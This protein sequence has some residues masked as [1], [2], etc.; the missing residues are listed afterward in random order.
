MEPLQLTIDPKA[1]AVVL[2]RLKDMPDKVPVA[3]SRAINAAL[4]TA[5]SRM[6]KAAAAQLKVPQKEVRRRIWIHNSTPRTLAGVSRAAKVG[7]GIIL[8]GA[9]QT[10]AG[11]VSQGKDY[12][13]AF[14]ATMK[15]GH[16]GAYVRTGKS[17]F[18]IVELKSDSPSEAI[19]KAAAQDA[20]VKAANDMLTHRLEI[21]TDLI[22][23]GIRK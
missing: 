19:E 8:F 12:P 9:A 13:H 11:V 23:K 14:L 4:A 16:R 22:L 1:L 17:R 10:K 6:T 20:I 7:W 2:D 3:V 15:S 5:K 21:E 18:P